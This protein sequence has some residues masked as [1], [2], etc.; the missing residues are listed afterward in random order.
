MITETNSSI[1]ASMGLW[2]RS[3]YVDSMITR[4][5]LVKSVGSRSMGV[6]VCPTS[7]LNTI[8]LVTPLSVAVTSRLAEPRMC[9]ASTQR[10]EMPG[11]TLTATSYSTSL[12]MG[13]TRCAS[14]TVYSGCTGPRPCRW[15][16]SG[17]R[18]ASPSW[19]RAESSSEIFEKSDDAPVA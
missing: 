14:S 17:C 9:P 2:S 1:V 5:A 12:N 16:F 7:P 15:R 18:S 8:V 6:G 19:M 3:P 13:C 4:S 11:A 10:A